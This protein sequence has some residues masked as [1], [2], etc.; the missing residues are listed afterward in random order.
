MGWDMSHCLPKLPLPLRD[1]GPHLILASL[2]PP[3]S[4]TQMVSQSVQL[5]LKS[6]LIPVSNRQTQTDRQ[7]DTPRY[8]DSNRPHLHT[9]CMQCRLKIIITVNLYSTYL[10]YGELGRKKE[11]LKE[12]F[13]SRQNNINVNL[14]F[15]FTSHLHLICQNIRQKSSNSDSENRKQA[16]IFYLSKVKVD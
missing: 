14:M 12:T 1:T 4:T 2:G 5:F 15:K 13:K 16:V 8:I 7:T 10:Q 9:P 11:G 6:S 3:E